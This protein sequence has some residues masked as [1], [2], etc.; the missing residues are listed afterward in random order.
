MYVYSDCHKVESQET[1]EKLSKDV[2][3]FC[4][5]VLNSTITTL[6][7]SLTKKNEF[8]KKVDKENLY[9]TVGEGL[10][11]KLAK[12]NSDIPYNKYKNYRNWVQNIRGSIQP[13]KKRREENSKTKFHHEINQEKVKET[14]KLENENSQNR[15]GRNVSRNVGQT[16]S[17]FNNATD[18]R[19]EY[20]GY[21]ER[22]RTTLKHDKNNEHNDYKFWEYD[23][24]IKDKETKVIFRKIFDKKLVS[25][26]KLDGKLEKDY[27]RDYKKIK[28]TD[29][30]NL[31]YVNEKIGK[32]KKN[33]LFM[34]G[35]FD[36]AYPKMMIQKLKGVKKSESPKIEKPLIE[37]KQKTI[38]K[39][40]TVSQGLRVVELSPYNTFSKTLKEDKINTCSTTGFEY[41]SKVALKRRDLYQKKNLQSSLMPK[42]KIISPFH[43]NS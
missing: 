20:L 3:F 31:K 41:F 29:D 1:K 32:I 40:R 43:I 10:H 11:R 6:K 9:N 35:V 7:N 42:I 12:S 8:L 16:L 30:E 18:Y 28:F 39:K 15:K 37:I 19:N 24:T 22:M 26:L 36:Y 23:D 21:D 25:L 33:I 38:P 17:I 5:K 2:N 13:E 27:K 14:I 4:G 34:K